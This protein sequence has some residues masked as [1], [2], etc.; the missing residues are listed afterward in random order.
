MTD[1][2]VEGRAGKSGLGVQPSATI[3]ESSPAAQAAL[4]AAL[5]QL[6]PHAE[7]NLALAAASDTLRGLLQQS[8][9]SDQNADDADRRPEPRG[10]RTVR[11]PAAGGEGESSSD[12]LE[13]ALLDATAARES[14]QKS[15]DPALRERVEKS[16]RLVE[17]EYMAQHSVGFQKSEVNRQAGVRY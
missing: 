14:V 11:V 4:R 2:Q 17:S 8:S 7:R 13:K 15:E 16:A 5:R 3:G 1:F 12:R 10:G 9:G 6:E